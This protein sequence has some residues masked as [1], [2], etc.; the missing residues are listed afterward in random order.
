VTDEGF[1]VFA[2]DDEPAPSDDEDEVEWLIT[3]ARSAPEQPSIWGR[4]RRWV[5]PSASERRERIG[6]RLHELNRAIEHYPD[7]PANF[8][9]R[10]E[11]YLETGAVELAIQDFSRALE[12]A[13]EQFE[14]SDW[15]V[16]AQAMRDRAQQGLE[17]ATRRSN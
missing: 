15:G 16:L 8:V 3:A 17:E 5:W 4:L 7:A 11:L 6:Q 12:L 9:V 13:T 14:E 10:G 1:P 2:S